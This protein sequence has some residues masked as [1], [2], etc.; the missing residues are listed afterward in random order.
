MNVKRCTLNLFMAVI[1]LGFLVNASAI[2]AALTKAQPS[3]KQEIVFFIESSDLEGLKQAF[4]DVNLHLRKE[5]RSL[6]QPIN[7][8]LH[9]SGVRFLKKAGMDSELKMILKWFQNER[10]NVGVCDG[11]LREYGLN[12]NSIFAGLQIWKNGIPKASFLLD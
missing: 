8:V 11:C 1:C 2:E 7:V 4:V 10:I 3:K 5:G 9:G 6:N 12:V